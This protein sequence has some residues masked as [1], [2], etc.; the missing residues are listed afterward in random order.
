MTESELIVATAAFPDRTA[1]AKAVEALHRK[2]F[3]RRQ[4][5]LVSTPPDNTKRN[6]DVIGRH[7]GK[8]AISGLISGAVLGAVCG[9]ALGIFVPA[10]AYDLASGALAGAIAGAVVGL[11][12]G[13]LT[14]LGM[15][16][17]DPLWQQRQD[18]AAQTVVMAA[19][20][21]RWSD[22]AAVLVRSGCTLIGDGKLIAGQARE[23]ALRG[24]AQPIAPPPPP[25][26][27]LTHERDVEPATPQSSSTP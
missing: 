8:G 11:L 14:G 2:G 12:L 4:T 26:P 21:E 17:R 15:P 19:A 22:A 6:A 16:R 9:G 24:E 13:A 7:R 23:V 3:H 18:A 27:P 1:A 10:T 20:G 25:P 5:G